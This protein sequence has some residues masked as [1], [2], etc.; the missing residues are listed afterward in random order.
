MKIKNIFNGVILY[1]FLALG[2]M[3]EDLK[4]IGNLD[5]TVR[6]EAYGTTKT[7]DLTD[8]YIL[9]AGIANKSDISSGFSNRKIAEVYVL[10][11]AKKVEIMMRALKMLVL[12]MENLM[13][14]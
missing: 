2:S 14:Y 11:E 8:K 7:Y 6:L 1:F 9:D 3:A 12:L 13:D 4:P 5:I 10:M